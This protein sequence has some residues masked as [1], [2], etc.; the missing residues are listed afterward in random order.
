MLLL[1]G[2]KRLISLLVLVVI[3]GVY[4]YFAHEYGSVTWVWEPAHITVDGIK[5]DNEHTALSEKKAEA[6]GVGKFKKLG[7]LA[8]GQG[9]YGKNEV[10]LAAIKEGF[11][12]V[13]RFDGKYAEY[14]FRK[15]Q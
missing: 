15:S 14:T 10:S 6:V 12:F 8:L 7:H 1:L 13:K 9:I 3:V 2:P 5:Y 4:G 11:V